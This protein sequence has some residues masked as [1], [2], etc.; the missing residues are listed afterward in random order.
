MEEHLQYMICKEGRMTTG[1]YK[2]V[3][4]KGEAMKTFEIQVYKRQSY[5]NGI[6]YY[7]T[8]QWVDNTEYEYVEAD[9]FMVNENN[10]LMFYIY[11]DTTLIVAYHYNQWLSVREWKNEEEDTDGRE[12]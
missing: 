3:D 5:N 7:T 6:N 9:Y 2:I 8:G 12:S 11:R 1:I 10:I 4:R